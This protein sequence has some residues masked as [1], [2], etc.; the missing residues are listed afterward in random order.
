MR[1]SD[2]NKKQHVWGSATRNAI[3]HLIPMK[4]RSW[5]RSGL[6]WLTPLPSAPPGYF[7]SR[8]EWYTSIGRNH[9]PHAHAHISNNAVAKGW[10]GSEISLPVPDA[11]GFL[12]DFKEEVLLGSEY[13]IPG[14]Q[15]HLVATAAARPKRAEQ[16]KAPRSAIRFG[17]CTR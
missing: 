3:P 5:S 9:H 12:P 6:F 1:R 7:P 16:K 14:A 2:H 15:L 17:A 4:R 10:T 8:K 13:T 11:F